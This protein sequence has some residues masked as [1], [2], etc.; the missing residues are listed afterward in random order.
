MIVIIGCLMQLSRSRL[1]NTLNLISARIVPF[2][3]FFPLRRIFPEILEVTFSES[4]E[5]RM[6][7]PDSY[8]FKGA[9]SYSAFSKQQN[10][11]LAIAYDTPA[12]KSVF[13]PYFCDSGKGLN[14]LWG[15]LGRGKNVY[16]D[17]LVV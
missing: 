3:L 5:A 13:E 4:C 17:A 11:L 15:Y 6:I 12:K 14:H 10:D 8:R 16:L 7:R 2:L 9:V 1:D